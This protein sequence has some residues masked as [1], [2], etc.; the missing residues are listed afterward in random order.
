M[1]RNRKTDTAPG[2]GRCPRVPWWMWLVIVAC[3]VPGLAFPWV[4]PL[5]VA[6]NPVVRGLAWFYPAYVVCTGLLA[7]QCYGRRTLMCWILLVLLLL[8][9]GCFYYLAG[10]SALPVVR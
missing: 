9:H 10:L 1:E 6:D 3:M 4:A 7:W 2:G 5:I 8:S